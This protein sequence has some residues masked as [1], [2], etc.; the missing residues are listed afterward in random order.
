VPDVPDFDVPDGDL[1]AAG[2]VKWTWQPQD[3]LPAWVAE[4]DVRPCPPVVGALEAAVRR[5]TLGYP[6]QDAV[7]GLPE[8]TAGVLARRL[9]WEPDPGLVVS[10][11]DVM[12]GVRLVLEVLC[13]PGPV[14]VPVPSYPPFLDVVPVTGRTVAAVPL[15]YDP[16]GPGG[17]DGTGGG[18][19]RWTLDLDG[20]EAAL[21]AGARTVLLSSPHNPTGRVWTRAELEGLRDVVVRHGARV[22]S[23]EVHAFL[24]LPGATHVP[25]ADIE[26]TAGHVTTVLSASKA[27]NIPG[28]KCAQIVAGSQ[29]DL[30]ALRAAPLVANHGLSPLGT[31]A[32]VAAYTDGE[33]WLDGVLA[34]VDERRTQLGGLLAR[35]VPTVRWTP[36]EATY[37]A[38]VDARGCGASD[39]AAA[40]L[41]RGRLAVSRGTDF[42]AGYG[43]FVRLAV[44]TSAERLER[45]VDGLAR[46]LGD[47]GDAPNG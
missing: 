14:V 45:I 21:A 3:V 43:G 32:T 10:C 26:G 40:C 35:A 27:W 28:V 5:G 38:W 42:G 44:A 20:I 34:H 23:D 37:L 30:R 8:A 13:D 41:R 19:G 17:T 29:G 33:A 46:S 7:T 31:V 47:P 12:A 39:P 16:A 18:P 9:G 11:G 1:R 36:M 6:S 4:M 22:I 2:S 24:T 25:Y 15:R